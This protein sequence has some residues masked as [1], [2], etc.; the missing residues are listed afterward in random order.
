MCKWH[1]LQQVGM[2]NVY[3]EGNVG[4]RTFQALKVNCTQLHFN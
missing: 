1:D 4:E 3:V 2:V